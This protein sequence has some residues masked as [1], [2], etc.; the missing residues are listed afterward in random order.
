MFKGELLTGDTLS[1]LSELNTYLFYTDTYKFPILLKNRLHYFRG[2]ITTTE[3]V[4]PYI[5]MNASKVITLR[6]ACDP[7]FHRPI[8]SAK[9]YDV[10][11]VGT[12]YPNRW[13]TMRKLKVKPH[14]FGSLWFLKVGH[15][16]P[17]VYGEDY[18]SVINS[19]KVNLNIHHPVDLTADSP[20]MRTFEVAGSGGFLLT[21][22]MDCLGKLFRRIET[23]SGVEEL[24]EKIEYYLRD[25]K[26][27]E[28]IALGLRE[29]CL[30]RHTY[31]HRAQELM[32][33]V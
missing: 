21:E 16:H 20:N 10:S 33:L 22:R 3:R 2:I 29:D 15:H 25:D 6:W 1:R 30:E 5:R 14:V 8:S 18:V 11:F 28:E 24:N 31:L 4:E 17:P 26:E 9:L 7:H 19:T 13:K 23:Y 12:F 27:R 32:R